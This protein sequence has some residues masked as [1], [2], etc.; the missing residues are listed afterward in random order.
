MARLRASGLSGREFAKQHG[1]QAENVYRWTKEFG[2]ASAKSAR[3]KEAFTEVRV[4]DG[5]AE[6]PVVEVVLANARVL[7]VPAT[8]DAAQLRALVEVVES[9]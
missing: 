1:L 7:R 4:G 5:A 2:G 8:I 6:P 3:G 9:C